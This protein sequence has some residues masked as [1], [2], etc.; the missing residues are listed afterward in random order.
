MDV[1]D[2]RA[3]TT[4]PNHPRIDPIGRPNREKRSRGTELG[5]SHGIHTAYIPN[6]VTSTQT[7]PPRRP[8]APPKSNCP[9][10][11]RICPLHTSENVCNGQIQSMQR[12]DSSMQWTAAFFCRE[13]GRRGRNRACV[14]LS[15]IGL[16]GCVRTGPD[17]NVNATNP[18]TLRGP[19]PL[20]VLNFPE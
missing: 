9:L 17:L 6:G 13:I 16:H 18:C 12:T 15:G 19:G 20:R 5:W 2:P 10:H 3:R 7:G 4:P 8:P 1:F 14:A 11:R